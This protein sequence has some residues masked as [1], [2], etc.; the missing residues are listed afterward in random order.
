MTSPSSA[1]SSRAADEPIGGGALELDDLRYQQRLARDAARRQ[2]MLHA[3]VDETLMGGMLVD[4]D[5]AVGGLRHDVGL[6]QLGARRA[7]RIVARRAIGGLWHRRARRR[8]QHALQLR[9]AVERRIGRGGRLGEAARQ[10]G[11]RAPARRRRP[12]PEAAERGRRHGGG[13]AVAGLGQRMLAGADDQPAHQPGV[14]EAHLGLGRMDVDVDRL[15]RHLEKQRHQRMA[16]AGEEI[17]VGAAH[18]AVQQPVAHRPAVDEEILL[19]RG[20]RD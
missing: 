10:H 16:V 20:A 1:S 15:G 17:L 12:R 4:D 2:L 5:D 19:R 6:V 8:R 14:A 11:T 3:L 13:G 9:R 18:R 7:E